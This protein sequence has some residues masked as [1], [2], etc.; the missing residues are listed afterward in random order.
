[1]RNPTEDRTCPI[2]SKEYSTSAILH[3]HIRYVHSGVK[4][5]PC[6]HCP[7]RFS[8]P[9]DLKV[10]TNIHSGDK[11]FSCPDCEKS[12]R[13]KYLL[14]YHSYLHSGDWPYRCP[15]CDKGCATTKDFDKHVQ[16]HSNRKQ[17]HLCHF[18]HKEIKRPGLRSRV[19]KPTHPYICSDCCKGFSQPSKSG[20]TAE[21]YVLICPYCN[22]QYA[23]LAKLEKHIE[24]HLQEKTHL[25]S[26]CGKGFYNPWS[27]NQHL[28][29]HSVKSTKPSNSVK[30]QVCPL[31][32]KTFASHAYMRRH[33]LT[34]HEDR[35]PHKCTQCGK[36]FRDVSRLNL[37]S[38]THTGEKP[39]ICS[40]CG[41]GFSQSG[42][43]KT[44]LRTHTGE[45]PF[46]CPTCGMGFSHKL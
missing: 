12:F 1:M 45:K 34:I 44:H 13:T 28:C 4:P 35:R 27:L 39:Y 20:S 43:L 7:Q 26:E 5:H 31:C 37:H 21:S 38:R 42:N 18:C 16:R 10:H 23:E 15:Y 30:S 29:S 14:R 8:R 33:M 9:G 24:T 3:D 19:R 40:V 32:C 17:K 36:A 6:P 11:P 46:V 2:C 22:K 41:K 25:C